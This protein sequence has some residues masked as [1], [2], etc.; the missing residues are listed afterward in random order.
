MSVRRIILPKTAADLL[1][2]ERI[3]DLRR[4]YDLLNAFRNVQL[5]IN[6][7]GLSSS[8][9]LQRGPG[10]A[11]L[12]ASVTI[13]PGDFPVITL[14]PISGTAVGSYVMTCKATGKGPLSFLWGGSPAPF[15]PN[16]PSVD[17][18][19]GTVD[20]NF[21]TTTFTVLPG[22]AP[23]VYFRCYISNSLGTAVSDLVNAA[24]T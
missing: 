22:T 23:F 24:A 16:D 15:G 5:V 4:A 18:S 12:V 6:S 3:Q 20:S 1:N 19:D 10:G 14:Q 17:L 2:P 9:Q 13:G 11:L 7:T 8:S 21:I